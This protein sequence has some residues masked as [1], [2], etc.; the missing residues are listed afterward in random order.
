MAASRRRQ[1]IETLLTRLQAIDG[2]GGFETDAGRRVAMNARPRWGPDDED[3]AITLMVND[4]APGWQQNKVL[5][6]LPF[7]ILALA[8]EDRDRPWMVVEQVL[9]DIKR[10]IELEDRSLGGLV[11]GAPTAEFFRGVT[12]LAELEEGA[13]TV[14]VQITYVVPYEESWGRP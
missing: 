12:Q 5:I 8:R 6:N 10:A 9:A 1:I 3:T 13:N 11:S 4:D 2:S 14:A 7:V